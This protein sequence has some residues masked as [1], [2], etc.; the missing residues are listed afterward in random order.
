MCWIMKVF[1]GLRMFVRDSESLNVT[2][3][4]ELA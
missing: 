1:E 4:N 2:W 3:N